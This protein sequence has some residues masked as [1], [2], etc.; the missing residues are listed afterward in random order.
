MQFACKTSSCAGGKCMLML[1]ADFFLHN[2]NRNIW[3]TKQLQEALEYFPK[4]MQIDK[5]CCFSCS[6]L[7]QKCRWKASG[8]IAAMGF[9][10]DMEKSHQKLLRMCSFSFRFN[11]NSRLPVYASVIPLWRLIFDPVAISLSPRLNNWFRRPHC[12]AV[13]I[14]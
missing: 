5:I 4:V 7:H 14:E 13:H 12:D 9:L 1:S 10:S 3:F 6:S 11:F 2:E 8:G